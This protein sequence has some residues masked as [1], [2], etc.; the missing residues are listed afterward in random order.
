MTGGCSSARR[1]SDRRILDFVDSG[2]ISTGRKIRRRRF[3]R[4]FRFGMQIRSSGRWCR[5]IRITVRESVTYC[6]AAAEADQTAKKP[7]M[8][9]GLAHRTSLFP[10]VPVSEFIGSSECAR[11]V[12]AAAVSINDNRPG[13]G[14]SCSWRMSP[15]D[16]VDNAGNDFCNLHCQRSAVLSS[17]LTA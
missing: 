1:P 9:S 6:V 10:S 5:A 4:R 16:V 11:Y 3:E 15:N 14:M 2:L 17:D 7:R 13:G 12:F 8:K